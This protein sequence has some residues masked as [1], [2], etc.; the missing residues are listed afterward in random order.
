MAIIFD[1]HSNCFHLSNKDISYVIGIEKGKYLT[2]R[3]WGKHIPFFTGSAEIQEIDRGF[4]T[5]PNP[6]E[7]IFS[8][9]S[10]P[11][12]TSTQGN[13][14][15]RI[16][17]YQ[18]RSSNGTNISDFS[19]VSHDIYN[20]KSELPGLPQLKAENIKVSTLEISLVDGYQDLEMTLFYSIYED[21]PIITRHVAFKNNGKSTVYLENAGSM[22]IDLP[23]TDFDMVT[24]NG[25]HTHEANISRQPLHAGIQKIESNRGTSSPQHQPFIA[26]AEASTTEFNG[27]VFAFHFIYSGNFIG[28]VEVEQYG[29]SRV[30]MGINPETFEWKLEPNENFHTPEVVLNY[31]PY[32]FNGM[33][34][35][36]H[37]IYQ[38]QLIPQYFQARERPILLNTW[39]ANYFD[40]NETELLVQADQAAEL[41]IELFVLDD[42]W[43]GQRDTDESSLGDWYVNTSKIPNGIDHL[44]DEVHERG[45]QF[46]LWFEP[47][48]ISKNSQLF[49]KHPE[50]ALQVPH[51]PMTEG[52]RQLVLD[53]SQEKVQ[54]FLIDT[55]DA[56]LSSGKIDYIKWD[57]NRHLTEV[58]STQF[59]HS[60]Q[61]EI[62][63]RYVLGLY[64]ILDTITK[65]YPH[66]LFENCSSGGGRFDPG[67]MYYM[68]QTWTSD[69]TDALSRSVIQY[70]FSYLYPPIMLGAHVSSVPNHQVGRITSLKTRGL[71]AMSGN[72][73]YEL[74][75]TQLS[76]EETNEMKK[77]IDFYKTYKNLFQFG[78]FYRLQQPNAYF[79]S[80]WLFENEHEAVLIYFNGL[81]RPAVPVTHLPVKYLDNHAVYQDEDTG[82]KVSGAELNNA[83]VTI[84]RIKGDFE[85]LR[86]HWKKIKL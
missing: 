9:N 83:G 51:Y 28:Q 25:S 36:F 78:R 35:T 76:V 67:M 75:V 15:H 73:G 54:N 86:F 68:A 21:Y 81:A 47:E 59:D 23:R 26:L 85:T 71:M 72:L 30:E 39:E 70:G 50:W 61:K 2:H 4:A 1:S 37:D 66:C 44:A 53:L 41:G 10:L 69:N 58:G 55:L 42:G 57:M 48:M 7:R 46:G 77:Q 18:I 49:E 64:H 34:Q 20:H 45:M 24:L 19:Y 17:N 80:A 33:S 31:S 14:D 11:L 43:F 8:L 60:Q 16:A 82:Q 29:S 32:G 22:M 52:R 5:N 79:A 65:R 74:D 84:P 12:E 62:Y 56:Y 40:I 27:D 13:G 38:N 3:Y 6:E 63:H